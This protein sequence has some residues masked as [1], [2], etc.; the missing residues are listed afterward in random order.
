[1]TCLLLGIIERLHSIVLLFLDLPEPGLN[2]ASLLLLYVT[3]SVVFRFA[4]TR[5]E[6]ARLYYYCLQ[7]M[8]R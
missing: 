2:S 6:Q 4:G 1:M 7:L 5:F 8:L 3:H